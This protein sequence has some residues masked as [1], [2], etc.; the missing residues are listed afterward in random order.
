MFHTR[1]N[2]FLVF[3]HCRDVDFALRYMDVLATNAQI[4]MN[5]NLMLN[6]MK[7]KPRIFKRHST[8]YWPNDGVGYLEKF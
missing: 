8:S 6:F 2:H 3:K 1:L 5:G 4:S 7:L